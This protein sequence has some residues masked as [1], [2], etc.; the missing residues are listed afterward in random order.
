MLLLALACGH[1]RN[2]SPRLDADATLG[3]FRA[4]TSDARAARGAMLHAEERH[5][6]P[7]QIYA[8]KVL[9]QA[10]RTF[11]TMQ[12]KSRTFRGRDS[13]ITLRRTGDGAVADPT[14]HSTKQW[15]T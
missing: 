3:K 10:V 13:T 5:T 15:A 4:T 11:I 2:T 6:R 12:S 1:L 9:K 7:L 14:L 8:R